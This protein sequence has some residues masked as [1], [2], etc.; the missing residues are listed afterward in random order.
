MDRTDRIQEKIRDPRRS[1]HVSRA[2][3]TE[4]ASK[5][6]CDAANAAAATSYIRAQDWLDT[7]AARRELARYS[8]EYVAVFEDAVVAHARSRREAHELAMKAGY[9]GRALAV[10]A[11]DVGSFDTL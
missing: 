11:V 8:G 5:Q 1:R 6:A 9:H 3:E 10:V 4:L 7:P 2:A